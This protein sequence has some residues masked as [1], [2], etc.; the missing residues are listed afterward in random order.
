MGGSEA[1][2]R[3]LKQKMIKGQKLDAFALRFGAAILIMAHLYSRNRNRYRGRIPCFLV[4][5]GPDPDLEAEQD[6]R[7]VQALL[8][9]ANVK[10]TM[11]Y[12]HVLNKGPM[13][14]VSPVDT[15]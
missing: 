14:V 1:V 6:I 7:S 12:T 3:P 9:H 13:G 8:R 11:I 15:L 5:F 10:T 2:A 4:D